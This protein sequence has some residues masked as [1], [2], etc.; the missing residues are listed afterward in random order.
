MDDIEEKMLVVKEKKFLNG[1]LKSP[2]NKNMYVK[3]KNTLGL[4][5]NR[6]TFFNLISYPS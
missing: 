3:S 4:L 2:D 5:K 6:F 1:R